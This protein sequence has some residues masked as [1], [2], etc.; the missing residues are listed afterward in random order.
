MTRFTFG[1]TRRLL[2][3]EEYQAVFEGSSLKVSN[4]HMLFLAKPNGL[5]YSRLGLV[6]AK[7]NIRYAVQRNRIKRLIRESFRQYLFKQ[8]NVDTI[9]LARRGLDQL[10]NQSVNRQLNELWRRL[11]QKS[12]RKSSKKGLVQ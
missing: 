1:K 12:N 2:K 7:K 4:K 10:D 5:E 8:T 11:D 6:I 9:V 3:A